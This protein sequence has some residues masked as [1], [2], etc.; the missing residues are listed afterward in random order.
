MAD[1]EAVAGAGVV[2]VVAL[3]VLDQPVVGGVVDTPHRQRRTHVVALGGVVVDHVEDHLDVG[4]VQRTHHRLELLH[5]TAGCDVGSVFRVGCEKA[6][7]VVAPVVR[8]PLVDQRRVVGEVVHRHQL[9]RGDTQRFEVVNDHRVGYRGVGA[10]DALRDVGMGLSQ[11]LDVGLVDDAV[12]VLVARGLVDTPVEEWADHHRLGH[13]GRRIVVVAAVRVVEVVAEQRLVP[14]EGAVDR[15]GI[16]VEQQLV[17]IA[18]LPRGRIV[19]AVHAVAVALTRL[20]AGQKAM[21]H[22]AIHLGQRDPCLRAVGVEQTQLDP[23]GHLAEHRE[24]SAGTVIAGAQRVGLTAPTFQR[25][26]NI[27]LTNHHRGHSLSMITGC[28][29]LRKE[30]RSWLVTHI[31]TVESSE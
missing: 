22:E 4:F 3:V 24:I 25:F 10:A 28:F 16:R 20:D 17:R 1:V 14:L 13:R 18:P 21:P 19:G 27:H 29:D 31:R 12:G 9:D 11:A 23:L 26:N 30:R 7:R 15:F 8:Q 2:H 5:L 6:D